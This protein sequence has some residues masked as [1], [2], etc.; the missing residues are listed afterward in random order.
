MGG[1]VKTKKLRIG[2]MTCISCQHKIEK[3]LRN[4]AGIR[5]AEVSWRDET[6]TVIYDADIIKLKDIVSVIERLDY[7]VLTDGKSRTSDTGRTA[8]LVLVIAAL[9]LLLEQTGVL[10]LLVPGSLAES[11]MSYGMLFLIGL[12][13][14]VHCVAM[15]GGINLS[16]C[17]APVGTAA[18]DSRLA[19]LKPAVFYNLGRV[20]SYTAVGFLVGALGS[21]VSLSNTF[22]GVLKLAAGVFMVIMGLNLLG[23]FPWLRRFTPRM[24]RFFA[25]RVSAGKASAKSPLLVGL[26]NGLMPCGPLQAMQ[27][28]ALSTGNAFAGAFSMFLFALGT[29]PLMF[30]LGALGSVLRGRFR[31]R[32]T[33]AGA[34][35]VAVLGLSMFSQGWSLT[36]F[37]LP[38]LATPGAAAAQSTGDQAVLQDGVQLVRS[39]LASGRYPNITVQEGVPVRWT[40]DAPQGSI[41][42]CNNA[43]VIPAYGVQHQFQQGENTIEFTPTEAGT[44]SYSCWMGMIRG[45]ITV[46]DAEGQ[47]ADASAGSNAPLEPAPAGITIP[48]DEVAVGTIQNGIQQVNIRLT[49]NGFEPAVMILQSGVETQWLIEKETTLP[50]SAQLLFPSYQTRLPVYEGENV[51]YLN[52]Q[53]SFDFSTQDS[54]F[55]GYVKV[56]EDI[57]SADPDAAKAEAAGFETTIYPP[58][59]YQDSGSSASCH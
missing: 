57:G 25:D 18:A 55:Y 12:M 41:N 2:G 46:L 31:Q 30:G 4:T 27:I 20:I 3:K 44:V 40:I 32:V 43:M 33:T 38:Q 9:Y 7:T 50:G 53:E 14:S 56:V 28:Y 52:P 35:L 26:L 48:T 47:P 36:G 49:D 45:V 13:T 11:G 59:Y 1:A 58:D 39:S 21:V 51:F 22:Q 8:G 15:C 54:A 19:A 37:A 42:G 6:A 17:I 23:I 10:N 29:V 5:M 34:V 16:Q 24:P